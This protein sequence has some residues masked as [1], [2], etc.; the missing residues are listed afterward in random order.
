MSIL[1]IL[2]VSDAL[3]ATAPQATQNTAG[4]LASFLPMMLI[5]I[6]G[7]YFL[8]IRPQNK[9]I[10]AQRKLLAELAKGDEVVTVGG[11]VGKI[12]KLSDDFVTLSVADN[13][14]INLQKAAISNVLPKGTL[15]TL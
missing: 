13:V 1:T 5:F 4:S 3:A 9:R 7:A 12:A 10:K 14:D 2:G 8:M 15:K 11:I 6:A